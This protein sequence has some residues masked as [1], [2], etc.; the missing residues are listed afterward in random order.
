MSTVKVEPFSFGSDDEQIQI[1][2]SSLPG[3]MTQEEKKEDK[4][5]DK[6]IASDEGVKKPEDEVIEETDKKEEEEIDDS[7]PFNFFSGGNKKAPKEKEEAEP[8]KVT[9][10]EVDFKG[11]KDFLV[12]SEIWKDFEG[13]EEFEYSEENFKALW[14]AQAENSVGEI[15]NEERAKFGDTANQLIE[16]LKSG[17]TVE[18]FAGNY[19]QQLDVA[20]IDLSDEDGQE[21]MIK[22]YYKSIDW[23]DTKIKKYIERLKDSGSD[24]F[25]EEA[26]DCKTKLVKEIE[27]Q[28][29]EMVKEQ[30]EIAKDRKLRIDKFN[31]S[32]RDAIYKDP[33]LADREKK[34]LDEFIFDY[35][36]KDENG[37]KWSEFAVKWQ[38][39]NKDPN[40]YQKFL[41]FV[42]DID[43]FEKKSVTEKKEKKEAFSFF[44]KGSNLL[45]GAQSQELIKKNNNSKTPPGFS[46]K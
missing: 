32:V 23:P 22:Q 34:A 30:E 15:L 4:K 18:D 40:K 37:N 20:A 46:F 8:K 7:D 41:K 33:D 9:S 12:S 42:K 17:G 21:E 26:E 6:P 44:K 13:S 36:H 24:D 31:S 39:I 14:K 27:A 25:K 28:R 11:L 35:K 2:S 5:D 38:E 1:D 16:Y 19:S 43:S 3:A 29:A 45:E 10:E